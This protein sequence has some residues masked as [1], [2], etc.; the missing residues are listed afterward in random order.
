MKKTAMLV[1]LAA[2]LGFSSNAQAVDWNWK[3]DIRYRYESA[4]HDNEEGD[5]EHSDD[6]HRMRVRLGADMWINEELS[7]GFEIRTGSGTTSANVDLSAEDTYGFSGLG[8]SL[9]EA[10][11]D[12]HPMVFDGDVSFLLGKRYSK[13]TLEVMDDLIWDGDVT[14]EGV[15]VRYG[16]DAKGKAKDGL[17]LAAGYYI[18][19]EQDDND[20]DTTTADDVFS[21]QG[22][23]YI[24]AAQASYK[25]E[26][27]DMK[28]Q[29]GASYYDYVKMTSLVPDDRSGTLTS[30]DYNI[31]ELFGNV[32]G[33]VSSLPWKL[34]AQY[35]MNTAE[36][37]K[38]TDIRDGDRDAYLVGVKLG[39]AKNPGQ[40]EGAVE[41]FRVEQFAVNP[42]MTDSD[43]GAT[44]DDTNIKGWKMGVKYALVQNMTLG[45]TYFNSSYVDEVAGSYKD[46]MD[47]IQAD[48]L[49]KF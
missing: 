12:F 49:V 22:D 33:K 2:V 5:V 35:A 43:R 20:S 37:S 41:Y 18:Y 46:S 16:K 32:S 39:K 23:A 25:G 42:D 48:V 24:L 14:L 26:A 36:S 11:I 4:Y 7:S 31:V 45:M 47:L 1:G 6:K 21:N 34:Y 3:G 30:I 44:L 13:E 27:S 38:Y 10:Y 17:E 40:L 15:T 8:I 29:A 19:Q 9:S 28:Y